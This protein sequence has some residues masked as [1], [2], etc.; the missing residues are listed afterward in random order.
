M[1]ASLRAWPELAPATPRQ[2]FESLS[3]QP[4]HF[5]LSKAQQLSRIAKKFSE[6][7]SF[8]LQALAR[9][10]R[11]ACG[12]DQPQVPVECYGKMGRSARGAIG[13]V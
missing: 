4:P 12:P 8:K 13:V 5:I 1:A 6:M 11:A 2:R 10:S 3:R 7:A 9:S